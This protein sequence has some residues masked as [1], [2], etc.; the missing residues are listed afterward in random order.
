MPFD[1][2]KDRHNF[3]IISIYQQVNA[4]PSKRAGKCLL[5][6]DQN[7]SEDG[8]ET[9]VNVLLILLHLIQSSCTAI[10]AYCIYEH[11][12]V[13]QDILFRIFSCF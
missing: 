1:D 6:V 7:T 12:A 8:N 5:L 11:V 10:P 9:A 13:S 3:Q 2:G 4:H